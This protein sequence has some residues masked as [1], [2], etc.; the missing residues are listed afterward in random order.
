MLFSRLLN[1]SPAELSVI[2]L[3][4]AGV[5]LQLSVKFFPWVPTWYERQT[6]KGLVMLALVVAT[7]LLYLGAACTPF[8]LQ[9]GVKLT[10][11]AS[12]PVTLIQAI[13]I[14][15]MGQSLAYLYTRSTPPAQYP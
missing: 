14:I 2:I 7:G 3:A 10:C 12:A 11:D 9:L 1:I 8:A 15:A 6:N 13:V 5:V 4:I